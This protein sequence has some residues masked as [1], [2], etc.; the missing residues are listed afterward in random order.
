[1]NPVKLKQRVKQSQQ[2]LKEAS[3]HKSAKTHTVNDFVTHDL[4]L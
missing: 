2:K 1:V 4:D 3:T